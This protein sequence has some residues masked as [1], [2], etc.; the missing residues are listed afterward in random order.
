MVYALK[1]YGNGLCLDKVFKGLEGDMNRKQIA[2]KI[3][4]KVVWASLNLIPSKY[5]T[6][7]L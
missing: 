5:N 6:D 1:M 7:W 4:Y 2:S 3:P